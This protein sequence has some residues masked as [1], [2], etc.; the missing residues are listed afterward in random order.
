MNILEA[1][2]DSLNSLA[3]R[4]LNLGDVGFSINMGTPFCS[5]AFFENMWRVAPGIFM[6][7]SIGN[8]T[9]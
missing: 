8:K 7:E 1:W 9:V 5:R 3:D 6:L 2:T 4:L